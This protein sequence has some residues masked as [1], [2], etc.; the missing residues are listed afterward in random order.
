[1][2]LNLGRARASSVGPDPLLDAAIE[3]LAAGLE[4]IRELASGLHPSVLAERGLVA[5]LES[6]ALRA[7][8]PV[9]LETLPDRRLPEPVEAAAYYVVA[10]A[11][12]NVNKHAGASRATVRADA[13]EHS[14]AVSVADDGVGGADEAGGG[15]AGLAD[16]VEALGGRLVLESPQGG[17]TTLR[18]EL[19]LPVSSVR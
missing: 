17:G 1:V 13:G 11:L 10:E 4:E 12:A 14:L 3:E 15:L 2:L 16:R 18:A 5:A 9:E 7:P 19:P 8:L 6:L